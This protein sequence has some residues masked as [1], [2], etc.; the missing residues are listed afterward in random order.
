[1]NEITV[2]FIP[3]M[4]DYHLAVYYAAVNRHKLGF[5]LFVVSGLTFAACQLSAY[6]GLMPQASFVGY[7][8]M[9]FLV[10]AI[11]VLAQL[12]S[13]ILKYAKSGDA[14][15][16]HEM[17]LSFT[18]EKLK[19]S[20]PYNGKSDVVRLD[21]LFCAI[22]ISSMFLIYLDGA[23]SI[24]LPHHATTAEQHSQIRSILRD[25][26]HDRLYTRND[27]NSMLPKRSPLRK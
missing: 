27:Y 25:N 3:T 14:L 19:I 15:I 7:I 10:W 20:T 26:L 5:R 17:T 4:R 12:E 21:S 2:T 13:G 6:F 18:R 22:E 11:L 23:Q 8:F 1:M 24:M 9:G 16:G